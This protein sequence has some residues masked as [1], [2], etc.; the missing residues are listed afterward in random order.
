TLE[1]EGLAW[2]ED[3]MNA[4]A[5][6][7]RPRLRA[8]RA[9]LAREG[10]TPERV[11]RLAGRIARYEDAVVAALHAARDRLQR[12]DAP[13]RPDARRQAA[14]RNLHWALADGCP[15]HCG[16]SQPAGRL[17]PR[18]PV[19]REGQPMNA[20]LRNLAL[21][22]IIVLLLLALFTLFQNPGQRTN[23]QDI[24][25]SQ[26][27]N[28]VDSGKVRDVVIQGAE[29]HGTFNNSGGTFQTYAPSDPTLVDR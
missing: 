7:A 19:R 9:A 18:R 5:R 4:D 11:A 21:W 13:G 28:D 15:A 27:L 29:I 10:L 3:P 17:S 2:S 23:S 8:A 6:F 12:P 16:L 20:N 26:F 22:V 25:F 14:G 1:R 24:T